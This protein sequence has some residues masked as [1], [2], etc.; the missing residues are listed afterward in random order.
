M[1]EIDSTP[2]PFSITPGEDAS[3]KK[4]VQEITGRASG[5]I[6]RSAADEFFERLTAKKEW[7]NKKEELNRRR[8]EKIHRLLAEELTELRVLKA[9]KIQMDIIVCGVDR[10]GATS[11][12]WMKAVET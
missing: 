2:E 12:V 8:F 10:E 7:H 9:G 6:A 5:P 11:G 1:S 3:D 4:I